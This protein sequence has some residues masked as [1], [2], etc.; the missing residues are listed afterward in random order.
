MKTKIVNVILTIEEF[1]DLIHSDFVKNKRRFY[2]DSNKNGELNA[3]LN[4]N[5]DS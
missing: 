2:L 1:Y 3:R 4:I 5:K